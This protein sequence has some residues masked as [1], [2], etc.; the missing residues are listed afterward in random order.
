MAWHEHVCKSLAHPLFL[1]PRISNTLNT[2]LLNTLYRASIQRMYWLCM[3]S[4]GKLFT[5]I[6][7]IICVECCKIAS[8]IDSPN[9]QEVMPESAWKNTKV[10]R[11]A[12]LR[13]ALGYF[14]NEPQVLQEERNTRNST[15]RVLQLKLSPTR[16]LWMMYEAED[17][18]TNQGFGIVRLYIFRC[19]C[20]CA[21]ATV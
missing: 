12:I 17:I 19:G 8:R 4:V 14:W 6:L 20:I 1:L 10:R 2:S 15:L 13:N 3:L 16:K 7:V 9:L 11:S 21:C 5:K 18:V